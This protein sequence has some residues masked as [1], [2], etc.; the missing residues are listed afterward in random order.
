MLNI[1]LN[2][3]IALVALLAGWFIHDFYRK[4]KIQKAI[5]RAEDI[6]KQALKEA[7]KKKNEILLKAKEEMYRLRENLEKEY[8][9]RQESLERLE[10]KLQNREK[11][12]EEREIMLNTQ[13]SRLAK[14]ENQL[15]Q[16]NQEFQKKHDE[17]EKIIARQNKKLET[18]S[19]MSLEDAKKMLLNNIEHDTKLEAVRINKNIIDQAKENAVRQAKSILTEAIQKI[20][21][22]HTVETTISVVNLASEEIKGRII[23]RDGRNI[24]TFETLSGVKV[25][26]DDTPEAVVLS[27]F[28]PVKRETAR[29]A[30]ERLIKNGKINPQRVEEM[31]RKSE[32]EMEQLIW[33]AGTEAVREVNIDRVHPELI[34]MLG[35]LRYRTSY[36]QNVLQHSKEVAFLTGAMAAELGL[37]VK[38]AKRA[39]LLHDIGKAISQNSENTHTQIGVDLA[40]KYK[41]HP[42]VINAIASHHEDEAA[43]NPISILVS[44]ADS[45]S[46]SRPGARRETLEGYVRRIDSLEKLAD[47]FDGV[48]K[49][50][51]I[52]AGREIRVIVK[53]EK[54]KDDEAFLLASEIAKKI[55]SD[56]EYP[57]HIKVTV[58]RETR[59]IQYV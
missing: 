42:V 9:Q 46:G 51:A 27:S 40:K 8:H 36:G 17:L 22:D 2:I 18:I 49:A 34:K 16:K 53:P 33:K 13:Q 11:S 29:L 47:S 56:M 37:D 38:L 21:S 7:N 5:Y 14:Q 54:V 26:V 55:Q 52:S 59:S 32:K 31:I 19:Q 25:I 58:M 30:L 1:I 39:G 35:R 4:K 10:N 3:G 45:I 41:E 20:A 24:K 6:E 57:G 12:L 28:D 50:Y 43:D 23:G 48:T 44:A 15:N